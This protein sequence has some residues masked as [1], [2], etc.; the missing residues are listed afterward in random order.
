VVDSLS[1]LPISEANVSV[2]LSGGVYIFNSSAST[3]ESGQ[4]VVE[5]LPVGIYDLI[6]SATGYA[7]SSVSGIPVTE[8]SLNNLITPIVLVPFT[9]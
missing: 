3:N 6:A 1:G 7:N 4:F 5:Q 8:G 9:P 2:T